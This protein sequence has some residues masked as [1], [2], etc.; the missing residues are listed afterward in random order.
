MNDINK[1]F[2]SWISD[3]MSGSSEL[4]LE[5][6]EVKYIIH[7]V[8][9]NAFLVMIEENP[10]GI[11]DTMIGVER[12][13]VALYESNTHTFLL[14]TPLRQ[15]KTKIQA[16]ADEVEARVNVSM[17]Q[18]AKHS[19]NQPFEV[20]K[21]Y[22]AAELLSKDTFSKIVKELEISKVNGFLSET[23]N[24]TKNQIIRNSKGLVE[25]YEVVLPILFEEDILHNK[26]E[27]ELE[28]YYPEL[29]REVMYSPDKELYD[30][31]LIT[32]AVVQSTQVFN[33]FDQDKVEFIMDH[34]E[35]VH[36]KL[37]TDFVELK[38][39][40]S[41]FLIYLET[42]RSLYKVKNDEKAVESVYR[43]YEMAKKNIR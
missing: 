2:N 13:V 5:L 24:N 3:E 21:Y 27:W 43:S 7:R 40:L 9:L 17:N 42:L 12:K 38:Q 33:F 37:S 15:D 22:I 18:I 23:Y 34:F 19:V 26:S 29:W 35:T 6:N 31:M 11:L 10:R 39:D 14:L 16:F 41:K 25:I 20:L 32:D 36:P 28:D 8:S 30:Y 1:V 4:I